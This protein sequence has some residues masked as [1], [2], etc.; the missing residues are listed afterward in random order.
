MPDR[1][2]YLGHN[3]NN[4]DTHFWLKKTEEE[5][6]LTW[7]EFQ[8]QTATEKSRKERKRE[9]ERVIRKIIIS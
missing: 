4:P 6:M 2:G 9:K 8:V 5:I 1:S 3:A 7:A